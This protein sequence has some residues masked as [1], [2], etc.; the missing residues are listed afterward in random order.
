M[1]Y[2]K[3]TNSHKTKSNISTC[4]SLLLPFAFHDF[5][6]PGTKLIPEWKTLPTANNGSG[7]FE[8]VTHVHVM[9]QPSIH[10]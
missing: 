5:F 6:P 4:F 2:F 8:L 10:L 3:L 1:R 7:S 9:L